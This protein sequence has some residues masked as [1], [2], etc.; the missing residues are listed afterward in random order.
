MNIK[1]KTN[2]LLQELLTS[3]D[4]PTTIKKKAQEILDDKFKDEV[5]EKFGYLLNDKDMDKHRRDV[6]MNK[7]KCEFIECFY[8][9]D[10][11]QNFL[12]DNYDKMD[13]IMSVLRELIKEYEAWENGNE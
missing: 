4:V 13:K 2:E 5:R 1:E 12:D 8:A 6:V 3:L 10:S 11:L 9:F 7:T